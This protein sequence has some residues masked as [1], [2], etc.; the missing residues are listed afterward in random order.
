MIARWLSGMPAD[1]VFLLG[2]AKGTRTPDPLLAKHGQD[3]QHR[4][5]PGMER[6]Q[7]P[8]EYSDLQACWCRLWVSPPPAEVYVQRAKVTRHLQLLTARVHQGEG[9]CQDSECSEAEERDGRERS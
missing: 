7:C 5:W 3:V 2:G 1:L 8:P 9:R 6:S 4:P